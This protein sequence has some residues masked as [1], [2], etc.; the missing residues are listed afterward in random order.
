[1]PHELSEL[2]RVA[3]SLPAGLV[4]E[5]L[6]FA[7]F[8]QQRHAKSPV[9]YEDWTDEAQRAATRAALARFEFEHPG[10]DWSALAQEP[11]GKE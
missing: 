11:E 8:L 4:R 5:V 9:E 3:E 7:L 6:D 2:N 1:M 10:E